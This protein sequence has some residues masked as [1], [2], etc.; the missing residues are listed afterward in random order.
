MLTKIKNIYGYFIYKIFLKML[1]L[2]VEHRLSMT[3]VHYELE[4]YLT[5]MNEK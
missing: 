2:D 3:L 5:E 1:E 4:N